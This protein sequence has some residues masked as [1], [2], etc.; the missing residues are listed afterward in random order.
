VNFGEAP[1]DAE[2]LRLSQIL[3]EKP[4]QKYYLSMKAC[5]GILNREDKRKYPLPEILREA[6]IEQA[7]Q[8]Q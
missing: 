4:Q 1:N 3:E 5:Q 8:K 6:L 2:E 7:K